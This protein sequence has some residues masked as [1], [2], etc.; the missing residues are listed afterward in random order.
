MKRKKEAGPEAFRSRRAAF[1]R[2]EE[3]SALTSDDRQT[4]PLELAIEALEERLTPGYPARIAKKTAG[5]GC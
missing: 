5:W 1:A 2:G 3:G 4:E